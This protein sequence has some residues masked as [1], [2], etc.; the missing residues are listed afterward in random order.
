MAIICQVELISMFILYVRLLFR[1]EFEA[2]RIYMYMGA[3]IRV[4]RC[5]KIAGRCFVRDAPAKSSITR[6]RDGTFGKLLRPGRAIRRVLTRCHMRPC[7]PMVSAPAGVAPG[8][9]MGGVAPSS[10]F[11]VSWSEV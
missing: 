5:F 1:T 9:D 11:L 3:G 6:L 4:A 7:V 8:G 2:P 10:S